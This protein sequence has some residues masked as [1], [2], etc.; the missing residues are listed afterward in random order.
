MKM[1]LEEVEVE[2]AITHYINTKYFTLQGKHLE[3]DFQVGRNPQVVT[4]HLDIVDDNVD[5]KADV[6]SDEE[7]ESGSAEKIQPSSE[8]QQKLPFS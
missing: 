3:I 2:L 8:T 5:E 7:R 1:I 6:I 4:A